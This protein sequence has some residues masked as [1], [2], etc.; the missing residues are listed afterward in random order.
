MIRRLLRRSVEVWDGEGIKA[1]RTHPYV[2][3]FGLEA[4][5]RRR[6]P[7]PQAAR[8]ARSFVTGVLALS[9]VPPP[10]R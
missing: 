3:R 5:V 7:S 9:S 1:D 2:A 8:R 10:R 6:R 4:I